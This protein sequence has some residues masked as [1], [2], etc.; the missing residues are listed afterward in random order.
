M[1][2][3]EERAQRRAALRALLVKPLLTAE[4][5]ADKLVLV[6]RHLTELRDWLNRETGWRLLADA[7]TAR[8]FKTAPVL[9]DAT[10]PAR[11]RAKEPF[12]RRR[13]VVLCLALAVLERADSQTTLGR[14]AEEVLNAAA[15]PGLDFAFTMESRAERADLVAVVRTLLDWGALRRVAGDEDAYLS[16]TGDVL[17]DVRRPV[18]ATLLTGA[19]GPSTIDATTFEERLAE[20]TAEP[21][22]D[23]DDLRNQAMRR[24][25]TR[26]LLEDPVVYYDDL[27]EAE[28]A[29]LV[30]QR[31]AITRRIE[32][33]TGLL[34]EI[35][36]EGI[37]MVDPDDELTDVRMPEQRT[38]GHVTLLVAEH[39]A[40]HGEAS[41]AELH[42]FVR[43]AADAHASFW[44]KGVTEPGAEE[45]LLAVALDKLVALQLVEVRADRVRGL[46]AIVRYALEEPT[47]REP[48]KARR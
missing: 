11:G 47:I 14:L 25:L 4:N 7:E 32:E 13:Y 45:E 30:S 19:R 46:P 39:L 27:D 42:A 38:D 21:V 3:D 24:R 20:L 34:P 26:R 36:A 12:G 44:R 10:H 23:T 15:E 48:G 18:L 17:Y 6:R 33:A 29:Y 22:A 16:A 31:Q 43:R 37:A 41:T 2:R 9:S 1:I 40:V 8:L 28:R 35:R 5:D